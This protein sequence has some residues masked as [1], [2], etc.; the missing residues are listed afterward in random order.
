MMR[1]RLHSTCVNNLKEENP[2][3]NTFC[4]K[5]LRKTLMNLLVWSK[6][7][8]FIFSINVFRS[9]HQTCSLKKTVLKN[10]AIFT[11]KHLF[12]SLFQNGCFRVNTAKFLRMP[13][14]ENIWERMLFLFFRVPYRYFLCYFRKDL[15][16]SIS[17]TPTLNLEKML[18]MFTRIE[19]TSFQF[20]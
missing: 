4:C 16:F 10:F 12:W 11:E 18:E 8:T 15:N 6:S 19:A 5:I 17:K 14:L 2:F 9:S 3:C 7:M 1:L 13:I 20:V